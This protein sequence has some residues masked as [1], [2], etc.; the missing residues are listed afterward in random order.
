MLPPV[1]CHRLPCWSSCIKGH[2]HE[3]GKSISLPLIS[4]RG[5][6]GRLTE[7]D[8]SCCTHDARARLARAIQPSSRDPS[9]LQLCHVTT[10]NFESHRVTDLCRR[11]VTFLALCSRSRSGAGAGAAGGSLD[12]GCPCVHQR[13][14][15]AI[16]V[17]G[18][19][20][21]APVPVHRQSGGL[22]RCAPGRVPTVQTV[23][24]TGEILQ[25]LFLD[26][27]ET[28]VVV[29]RH[30]LGLRQC[31]KLWKFHRCSS[32]TRH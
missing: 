2:T 16:H 11:T 19:R 8:S 26:T 28:P 4:L 3:H 29:Q 18:E 10:R 22:F 32:W 13:Q 25:V 27:V 6:P 21:G 30:V 5:L 31:R 14:V 12:C 23:Q 7:L 15:P 24:K 20:G 17:V 9:Q 1:Y